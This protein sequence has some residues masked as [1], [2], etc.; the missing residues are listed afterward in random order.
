MMKI[1]IKLNEKTP[2]SV[3][4]TT[5]NNKK[6]STNH[7]III[8]TRIQPKYTP[9][10]FNKIM[11]N[12]NVKIKTLQEKHHYQTHLTTTAGATNCTQAT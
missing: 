8:N 6:T 1:N 2:T 3:Q 11:S 5:N 12:N 10:Y 7:S 4:T 9:F